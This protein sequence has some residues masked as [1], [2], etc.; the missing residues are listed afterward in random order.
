M[1]T[2]MDIYVQSGITERKAE[3]SKLYAE[4]LGVFHKQG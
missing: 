3:A 2:H 1:R 4:F